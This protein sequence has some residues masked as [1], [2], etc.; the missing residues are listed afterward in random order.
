MTSWAM[1]YVYFCSLVGLISSILLAIAC[2][3]MYLAQMLM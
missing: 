2:M 3:S 1:L